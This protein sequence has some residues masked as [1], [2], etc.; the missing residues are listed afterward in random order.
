MKVMKDT[1]P[2][3]KRH[4]AQTRM[5]KLVWSLRTGL[6]AVVSASAIALSATD[7]SAAGRVFY[8]GFEDG[9]T[10]AWQ[11]YIGRSKCAVVTSA[12]DGG[13]GAKSGSRMAR[14]NWNGLVDWDDP[15]SYETLVLRSWSMNRETLIR[16][17]VRVD[18]DVD[19]T[20]GS[21]LY[22]WGGNL[23]SSFGAI[24]FEQGS[25][26]TLYTYFDNGTGAQIG[27]TNWG[28]GSAFR[29]GK[30]HKV[31]M[32]MKKSLSGSDGAL[33][34]WVDGSLVWQASNVSTASSYTWT[35][36][37]VMSNWS[38]NPG[39]EH[40]ANNHIYWDEFEIYSDAGSGASGTLA[41]ATISAGGSGSTITVTTPP[42]PT[43]QVIGVQ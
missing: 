9:T 27:T 26:A 23:S 38:S 6:L 10:N 12:L 34:V 35:E 20:A 13:V 8:D 22:R 29:D 21:K 25:G 28:G 17:W 24:Q 7:A 39:W 40:D 5:G 2:Q 32:Y 42:A 3:S 33:K 14:C 11:E 43:L 15:R 41:D 30:W 37:L 4:A 36:F 16:F 1:P 31:E 19:A 18:K